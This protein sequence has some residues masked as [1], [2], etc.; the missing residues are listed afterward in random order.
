MNKITI[1]SI[2]LMTTLTACAQLRPEAK[3]TFSLKDDNQRPIKGATIGISTFDHA[4]PVDGL[5]QE[6]VSKGVT[7]LTDE[8]GI[9][10]LAYPSLDGKIAYRISLL[11]GYY[12]NYG[13]QYKFSNSTPIGWQPWNPTVDLILRPVVRP[14]PMYARKVETRIASPTQ[15]YGYD[16][17]VGDWVAPQGKGLT[18]DLFF[19]LTGYANSVKD[20]NST[21][22]VSFANPL[23][24]IQPFTPINSEFRSPRESPLDGYLDKLAVRRIRKPGQLSPDWIDDTQSA[25]NYFLRVRTILDEKGNIKSALYGKI[26][27][28]FKFFG[29][30]TDGSFLTVPAYYLNPESN[31]RNME[32]DPG[33]NL[34][35]K[36]KKGEQVTAP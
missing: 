24:G 17:I 33:R 16:L 18:S 34:F 7:G 21:L 26:H 5:S 29:A 15:K 11:A 28:G 27:G 23:D 8:H 36:L 1:A 12:E 2:L 6:V 31:S 25:T 20:Y 35:K 19:E 4:L 22:I 10:T 3:I 32:F 9:A 14:V 30:A 13:G